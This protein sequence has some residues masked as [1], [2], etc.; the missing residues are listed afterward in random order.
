M[1]ND[2]RC[3]TLFAEANE[4]SLKTNMLE[5]L[6]CALGGKA[7]F[8]SSTLLASQRDQLRNHGFGVGQFDVLLQHMKSVLDDIG[9]HQETAASAIA[10]LRC[11]KYL[12]E[13]RV[14]EEEEDPA[15]ADA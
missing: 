11:H 9:I 3:T 7:R 6:T 1:R 13:R 12:F 14:S 8:A 15:L 5:F 10:L 2:Q 4:Q